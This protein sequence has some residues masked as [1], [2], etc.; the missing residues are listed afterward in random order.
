MQVVRGGTPSQSQKGRRG[1]VIVVTSSLRTARKCH[2]NA[3][4]LYVIMDDIAR[5]DHCLLDPFRSGKY[6][7]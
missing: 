6:D 4:T 3:S 5:M 7:I 2:R 1:F